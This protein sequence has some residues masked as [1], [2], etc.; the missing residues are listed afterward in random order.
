MK[1]YC[2]IAFAFLLL[3]PALFAG[4]EPNQP[5]KIGWLSY[6]S[7]F[8]PDGPKKRIRGYARIATHVFLVTIENKFLQKQWEF[9]QSVVNFFRCKPPLYS[10]CVT[11]HIQEQELEIQE[12]SGSDS[13]SSD[14]SS[15]T[16][17]PTEPLEIELPKPQSI[18]FEEL[19]SRLTELANFIEQVLSHLFMRA[20]RN[21]LTTIVAWKAMR[22][23]NI[24]NKYALGI[25]AS[26]AF[27][28]WVH[29]WINLNGKIEGKNEDCA[30]FA[31]AQGVSKEQAIRL[32]KTYFKQHEFYHPH[33]ALVQD[34]TASSSSTTTSH[35]SRDQWSPYTSNIIKD[36]VNRVIAPPIKF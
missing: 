15:Q 30:S 26:I 18:P 22:W 25:P 5:Q 16:A 29:T 35:F 23:C 8:F 17:A 31:R 28:D 33:P 13:D 21:S 4:Q 34:T 36:V 11:Q 20:L 3:E 2:L 9:K 12:S 10:Q 24:S 6:L 27:F 14:S 7:S 19:H 1:I 32:Y